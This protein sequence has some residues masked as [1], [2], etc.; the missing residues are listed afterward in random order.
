MAFDET[1]SIADVDA[2]VE[3]ITGKKVRGRRSTLMK[4]THV[5]NEE[6]IGSQ[7]TNQENLT[8][9]GADGCVGASLSCC[10]RLDI[11]ATMTEVSHSIG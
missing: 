11:T 4:D 1:S 2:L 10:M 8:G 7:P 9:H 6:D 3:A 5:R